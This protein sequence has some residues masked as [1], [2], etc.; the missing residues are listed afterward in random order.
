[1]IYSW[2]KLYIIIRFNIAVALGYFRRERGITAAE[3]GPAGD[4]QHLVLL[5]HVE[6]SRRDQDGIRKRDEKESCK[7]LRKKSRGNSAK[8]SCFY[9]GL[10][11]SIL[12]HFYF[13]EYNLST[14]LIKTRYGWFMEPVFMHIVSWK[15]EHGASPP[16]TVWWPTSLMKIIRNIPAGLSGLRK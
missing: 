4:R 14:P 11:S 3:D 7:F 5:N 1:M 2:W 10:V 8:K 6:I 13:R 15:L 9:C 16:G 12:G